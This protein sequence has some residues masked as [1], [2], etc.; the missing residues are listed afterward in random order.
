M[1]AP[2]GE[3]VLSYEAQGRVVLACATVSNVAAGSL[4][5]LRRSQDLAALDE[6]VVM[7]PNRRIYV[8]YG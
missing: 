8:V 1:C 7:P 5:M 6:K 3:P 2:G 4:A